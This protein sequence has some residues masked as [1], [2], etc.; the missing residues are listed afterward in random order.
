MGLVRVAVQPQ[1]GHAD[2]AGS[3][4]RSWPHLPARRRT[5]S[6]RI[7]GTQ[8]H[9]ALLCSRGGNGGSRLLGLLPDITA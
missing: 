6:E 2:G 5:C 8:T 7:P 4:W 9:R 3:L 1:G